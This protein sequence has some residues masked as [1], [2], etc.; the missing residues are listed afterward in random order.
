MH[1]I[2]YVDRL[3]LCNLEL[4]DLRHLHANLIILYKILNGSICIDLDN[5]ICL[6]LRVHSTMGNR[7]KLQKFL[8]NL[9]I[10]KY[11]F[12]IQTVNLWNALPDGILECKMIN[13]FVTKIKCAELV[14]F[15]K[16]HACM[17]SAICA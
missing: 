7:L 6:S 15:L 14:K 3:K 13:N 8:A 4:L 17:V 1:N 11:F 16:V 2:C 9:N 10:R 12:A 5:C